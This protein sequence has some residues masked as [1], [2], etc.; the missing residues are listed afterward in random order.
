[1]SRFRTRPARPRDLL[2]PL[3]PGLR[4]AH[5]PGAREPQAQ[6]N[7]FQNGAAFSPRGPTRFV[8]SPT[9]PHARKVLVTALEKELGEPVTISP[10]NSDGADPVLLAVNPPSR[11][12]TLEP[13]AGFVLYDS[14]VICEWLDAEGSGP[15]LIPADGPGR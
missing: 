6:D 2:R 4:V 12:P 15:C 5:Q 1:M 10:V 3:R 8:R 13:D 11:V 7:P 14:P 9:T